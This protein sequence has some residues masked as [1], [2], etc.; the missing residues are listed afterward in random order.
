MDID[1]VTGGIV[2]V[3]KHGMTND[4]NEYGTPSVNLNHKLFKCKSPVWIGALTSNILA[5]VL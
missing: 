2:S 3:T 5:I 1:N 4:V